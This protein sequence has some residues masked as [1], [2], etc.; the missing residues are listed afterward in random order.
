MIRYTLGQQLR[1]DEL[2]VVIP[3]NL[4][5]TWV[6]I[7]NGPDVE[8]SSFE[9]RLIKGIGKTQDNLLTVRWP[10][11]DDHAPTI[12]NRGPATLR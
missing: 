10:D 8:L 3:G 7:I 5:G 11:V 1:D 2:G 6:R 12:P 4:R 9:E